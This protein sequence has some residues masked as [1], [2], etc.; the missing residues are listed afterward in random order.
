MAAP[1]MAHRGGSSG[2]RSG[3]KA[4]EPQSHPVGDGIAIPSQGNSLILLFTL[5][6]IMFNL[7]DL[8]TTF[9]ALG[10]GLAEGNALVLGMSAALGLDIFTSLVVM[11]A[12]F[13]LGAAL[14]ALVGMRSASKTTR[15]LA[16]YY[17]LTSAVIFCVVSLNNI[18]WILG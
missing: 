12:I 10:R 3:S 8:A 2:N 18:A 11:K 13:V 5:S 9:A 17:L 6:S 14:V 16:Q 15:R 1:S 7:S 4:F